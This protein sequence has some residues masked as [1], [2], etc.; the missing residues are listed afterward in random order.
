MQLWT[1]EYPWAQL[2]PYTAFMRQVSA[3]FRKIENE[4]FVKI[5]CD[6][7]AGPASLRQRMQKNKQQRTPL[8]TSTY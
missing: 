4:K 6:L 5:T 2:H 7:N 1:R 8:L 3:R